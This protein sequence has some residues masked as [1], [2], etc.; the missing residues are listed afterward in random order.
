MQL[1]Q[2][3]LISSLLTGGPYVG[4]AVPDDIASCQT[5]LARG[6]KSFAAAS[7]LLPARI[8]GDVAAVYAFCRVA[9][10]VVD[11]AGT[12]PGTLRA[13]DAVASLS[14]RLDAMYARRPAPDP[15]DRALAAVIARY[16]LP[17]NVWDALLEGFV[18][19]V[20]GRKYETLSDVRAYGVRVA[21]TVG[22]L[23]TLLMGDARRPVLARACD[24]GVAMQLTNIARDVGEDAREGR[25]YLPR[26]WF[27]ELGLGAEEWLARPRDRGEIREMTRRLL[28]EAEHLYAR[29]DAGIADLPRDARVAIRA[30]RLIYAEIGEAVAA[31][32]YDSVS[33]RAFTSPQR[34]LWLLASATPAVWWTGKAPLAAELPE[35][36]SLLDGVRN[37]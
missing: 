32:G 7:H 11:R 4:P 12:G 6:S 10:D 8:R 5:I 19:D 16:G 24:L 13:E 27:R 18:W 22:V 29:A 14:A 15:V 28:V 34:K 1:A 9:D 17:R 36:K 21:S 35:A 23:M 20:S 37:G 3:G 26:A 25:L 33:R 31:A 30:A 2:S